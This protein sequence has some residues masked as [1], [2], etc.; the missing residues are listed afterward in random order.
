MNDCKH[1]N[2]TYQK[3]K[4]DET[5]DSVVFTCDDCNKKWTTLEFDEVPTFQ[6]YRSVS[7]S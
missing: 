2:I 5:F 7:I 4:I 6:M 1:K 3:I